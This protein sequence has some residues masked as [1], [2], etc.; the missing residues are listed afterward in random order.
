M[1]SRIRL[2]PDARC[3]I[4]IVLVTA[5]LFG[6]DPY[7]NRSG[8]FNAGPV[9]PR[10]FP[11]PYLG[12]GGDPKFGG[13]VFAPAPAWVAGQKVGYYAFPLSS[14]QETA[15]EMGADPLAITVDG[16]DAGVVSAPLAYV[17]DPTATS[18]F[19]AQPRCTP[20]AS[21]VYDVQRDGISYAEQGNV[22]TTLPKDGSY[23]PIVSEVA[24]TSFAE[25]C[26]SIK[27]VE[28]LMSSTT[29]QLSKRASNSDTGTIQTGAPD[30]KYLAWAL[31][32]PGAEVDY[33]SGAPTA[34]T[35][36]L[37]PQKF[38]WFDHY[39]TAYL[40]G[41]YIPTV[42]TTIPGMDGMPD[43]TVVDF[44][45]QVLYVPSQIPGTDK[46]GNPVAVPSDGVPGS[47]YDLLQAARGSSGYS[48]I[49]QVMTF[50]PADP[51]NPPT[52]EADIDMTTVMPAP[53]PFIYCLQLQ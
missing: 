4:G 47:G 48:P 7:Q 40:D 16:T 41:G 10:S 42:T 25:P 20:P 14:T 17:F 44:A 38:G 51:L 43:S 28:T 1:T 5:S 50:D 9:D 21:Y 15:L 30:G 35:H 36:Y 27:S 29:V 18:P 52:D 31:I 34:A 26:Q 46:D 37:G 32:D 45:T 8:E 22:F 53:T 49:C 39:L 33:L 3:G 11:A 19:P 13:G 6:C 23:A 2:F 12:T 24:V